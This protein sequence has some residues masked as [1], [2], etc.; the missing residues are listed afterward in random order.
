M[1]NLAHDIDQEQRQTLAMLAARYQ[2]SCNIIRTYIRRLGFENHIAMKTPYLKTT[3]KT[4]RLAFAHQ[5]L[6]WIAEDR[7]KVIW[8][9]D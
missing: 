3:H 6:H 1:G 5:F 7:Y 4:T 2:M 9:N 8:T